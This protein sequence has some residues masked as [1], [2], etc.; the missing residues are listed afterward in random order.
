MHSTHSLDTIGLEDKSPDAEGASLKSRDVIDDG[1]Y[2]WVVVASTLMAFSLMPFHFLTFGIFAPEFAHTFSL[3][4]SEVG[5][6]ASLRFGLF[7]FTGIPCTMFPTKHILG[8]LR[9][10]FNYFLKSNTRRYEYYASPSNVCVR[11]L[12]MSI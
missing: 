7:S 9:I 5:L 12:L 4:E 2:G 3:S 11:Q 10:Y 6:I 1:G 8:S